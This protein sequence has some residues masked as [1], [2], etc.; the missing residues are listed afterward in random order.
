MRITF[1]IPTHPILGRPL[2]EAEAER[3]RAKA[4]R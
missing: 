1:I 2:S 4:G 3:I